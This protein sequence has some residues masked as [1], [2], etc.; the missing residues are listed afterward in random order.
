MAKRRAVGVKQKDMD[1]AKD[2]LRSV[3]GFIETQF[4][5]VAA[6]DIAPTI[7]MIND[8]YP[9]LNGAQRT[10]MLGRILLGG[11]MFWMT[12]LFHL[13][14]KVPQRLCSKCGTPIFTLGILQDFDNDVEVCIECGE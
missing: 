11:S 4:P 3:L 2:V 6:M 7:K 5:E 14:D 10:A 12:S 9:Q 1:N 13:K 8:S